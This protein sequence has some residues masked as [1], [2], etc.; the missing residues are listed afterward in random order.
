[1]SERLTARLED[2][3]EA[4]LRIE[5]G[6]RFAR[7]RDISQVLTVAKSAVTAALR[8]LSD[9]ELVNYQPYEPVTLTPKGTEKAKAIALRHR[10]MGDFLQHILGLDPDG[11]DSI[12]CGMEHAID[13]E[14]LRRFVCF[15]AFI[16]QR[17]EGG[18]S[19]LDEFRRFISE[20]ADGQ[21][22]EDC[23]KKYLEEMKTDG[24]GGP[25]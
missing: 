12:A 14:A 13:K 10:I 24:T 25:A 7:V 22:C 11:A 17:A 4:I 19:W 18:R 21:T 15:L 2:Y 9:M 3:L 8:T 20:G 23:I 5:Q 6:K 1:M 16:G